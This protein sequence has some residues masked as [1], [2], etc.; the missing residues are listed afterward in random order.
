M[1][2]PRPTVSCSASWAGCSKASMPA[3]GP[4]PS[5]PSTPRWPATKHQRVSCSS[6]PHGPSRPAV[7]DGNRRAAHLCCAGGRSV[8]YFAVIRDAGPAWA[9]GKGAF[10][11]PDVNDH[12][13]FMNTLA[14]EGLV[15]FAGP[16]AGS[17]HGRIRVLLIFNADNEA[18]IYSR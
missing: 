15:L 18:V 7:R 8:T 6:Q 4:R 1:T 14:D 3:A 10:E 17:E 9:D 5:T 2:R 16:L 12:G 11:Q 13:A